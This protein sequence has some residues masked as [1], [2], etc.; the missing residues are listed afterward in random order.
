MRSLI[1]ELI[2]GMTFRVECAN[3]ELTPAGLT[4]ES[5]QGRIEIPA[6][7][8]AMTYEAKPP[9]EASATAH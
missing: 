3:F 1:I 5:D 4:I 7:R 8:I 6:T 2:D 9:L